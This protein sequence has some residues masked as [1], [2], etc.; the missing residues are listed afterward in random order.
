MEISIEES[1][2]RILKTPKGSRVMRPLYGTN[3]HDFVDKRLTNDLKLD[4]ISDIYD[5]VNENEKRAI[6]NKVKFGNLNGIRAE[7][8]Y[9][10]SQTGEQKEISV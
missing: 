7:I 5:S 1:I 8:A 6:I 10:E 4:L 3:L 2:E 9:T